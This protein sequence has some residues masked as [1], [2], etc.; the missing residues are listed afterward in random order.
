MV[1]KYMSLLNYFNN[2]ASDGIDGLCPSVLV[3]YSSLN[4]SNVDARYKYYKEASSPYRRKQADDIYSQVITLA[5]LLKSQLNQ[6]GDQ[7]CPPPAVQPVHVERIYDAWR[8][9][10]KTIPVFMTL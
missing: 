9:S 5:K 10:S 7:L 1:E 2:V 3:P 8:R 6:Y 4:W